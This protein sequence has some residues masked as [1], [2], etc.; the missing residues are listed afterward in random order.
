M[1]DAL[2]P[3]CVVTSAYGLSPLARGQS[4]TALPGHFRIEYRMAAPS[5]E[6]QFGNTKQV[7]QSASN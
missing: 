6:R 7:G 3:F 1:D 2:E 5:T 4:M